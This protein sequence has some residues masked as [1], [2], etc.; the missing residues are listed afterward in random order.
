MFGTPDG[1]PEGLGKLPGRSG[2]GKGVRRRTRPL[3]YGRRVEAIH[4]IVY[5]D[6]L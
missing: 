4:F 5:S 2:S 1:G 6:Y 3:C